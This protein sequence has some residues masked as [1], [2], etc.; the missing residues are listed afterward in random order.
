MTRCTTIFVALAG[1]LTTSELAGAQPVTPA[2]VGKEAVLS[3]VLMK[4]QGDFGRALQSVGGG[5]GFHLLFPM[6]TA[7]VS[8][9]IDGQLLFIRLSGTASTRVTS[10]ARTTR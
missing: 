5:G 6:P 1:L 9:G 3:G 10:T 8:A 7:P 2:G 4:P